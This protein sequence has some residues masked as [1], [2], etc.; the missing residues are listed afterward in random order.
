MI[1]EV[2]HIYNLQLT[3][4]HMEQNQLYLQDFV[5]AGWLKTASIIHKKSKGTI[6]SADK[7]QSNVVL[8]YCFQTDNKNYHKIFKL[9]KRHAQGTKPL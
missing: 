9:I 6:I 8:I 3:K 2:I 7:G 5:I 1:K 4:I